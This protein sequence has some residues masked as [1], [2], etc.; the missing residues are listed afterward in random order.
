MASTHDIATGASDHPQPGAGDVLGTPTYIGWM[1]TF[2]CKAHF[3]R[4]WCNAMRDKD[5][6]SRLGRSLQQ[7]RKELKLTQ[8]GLAKKTGLHRTYISLLER[9]E[10][11]PTATTLFR[12]CTKL[13]LRPSALWQMIEEDVGWTS[14][15]S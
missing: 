3:F 6:E 10:R 14:Q 11:S 5:L 8:A 15:I 1:Q 9:G 4:G 2:V 13:R 7:R 12:V